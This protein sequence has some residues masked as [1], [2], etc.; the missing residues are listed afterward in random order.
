MFAMIVI[1]SC[2]PSLYLQLCILEHRMTHIYAV[3]TL[4]Q[5]KFSTKSFGID[6]AKVAARAIENVAGSLTHADISDILAGRPEKEVLGA[7]Q[8]ISQSLSK[9]KLKALDLSD[10]ALGQKGIIACTQ[11]FAQQVM[12]LHQHLHAVSCMFCLH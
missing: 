12:G 3:S 1:T 7:L 9:A 4:L 6:A 11:A 10:N 2:M 8:L 5:I